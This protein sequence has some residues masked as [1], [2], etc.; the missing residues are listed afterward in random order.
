[1][2]IAFRFLP[3]AA[4]AL[5]ALLWIRFDAGAPLHGPRVAD[6]QQAI[7]VRELA[8]RPPPH[9]ARDVLRDE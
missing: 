2:P 3:F 9:L 5:K 8:K 7:L 6:Q 4:P 1:M